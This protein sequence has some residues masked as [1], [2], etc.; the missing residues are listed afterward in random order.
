MKAIVH[1]LSST[2]L[3]QLFASTPWFVPVVQIFHILAICVVVSTTLII[4]VRN[5]KASPVEGSFGYLNTDTP[6][7]LIWKSTLVLLITGLLLV[8]TE[9]GR[10]LLNPLFWTKM[11]MLILYLALLG[12]LA[13][14]QKSATPSHGTVVAL[15]FLMVILTVLLVIAGRFIAYI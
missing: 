2:Q 5:L 6:F 1:A 14:I 3:S 8:I 7:P 13:R 10:E 4:C 12:S 15:S 9:P 11:G